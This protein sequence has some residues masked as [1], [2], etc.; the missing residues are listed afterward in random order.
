MKKHLYLLLI[1]IVAL[2]F[3]SCNSNMNSNSDKLI[4]I[5]DVDSIQGSKTI[6]NPIEGV[7]LKF[8]SKGT[9]SHSGSTVSLDDPKAFYLEALDKNYTNG[10]GMV[11]NYVLYIPD[12]IHDV[13]ESAGGRKPGSGNPFWWYMCEY[14]GKSLQTITSNWYETIPVL[15]ENK[16]KLAYPRAEDVG[17]SWRN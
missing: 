17:A 13:Y 14:Y 9:F 2:F 4:L 16:Q 5:S 12:C 3:T 7:L 11:F 10:D 8:Q 15:L 1:V 6:G